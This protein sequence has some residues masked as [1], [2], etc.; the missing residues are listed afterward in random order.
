M[1]YIF[2][3]ATWSDSDFDFNGVENDTVGWCIVTIVTC[4]IKR[5]NEVIL[6]SDCFHNSNKVWKTVPQSRVL[7]L[8]LNHHFVKFMSSAKQ[9]YSTQLE[10]KYAAGIYSMEGFIC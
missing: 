4:G 2:P 8:Y 1:F 9:L 7:E 10:R 5:V 3:Y 6:G